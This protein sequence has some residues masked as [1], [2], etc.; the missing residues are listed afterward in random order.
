[1]VLLQTLLIFFCLLWCQMD[2]GT[3]LILLPLTFVVVIVF[4]FM[5]FVFPYFLF[6]NLICF[7]VVHCIVSVNDL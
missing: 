1:V 2:H 4:L 6:L 3:L 7:F 5:H